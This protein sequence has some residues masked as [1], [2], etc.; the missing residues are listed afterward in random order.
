MMLKC[1]IYVRNCLKQLCSRARSLHELRGFETKT[2]ITRIAT[3]QHP[4]QRSASPTSH[5]YKIAMAESDKIMRGG[6]SR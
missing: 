2:S 5:R 4:I 1:C 3:V 6:S